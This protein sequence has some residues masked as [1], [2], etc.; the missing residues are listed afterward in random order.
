MATKHSARPRFAVER[1]SITVVIW[2]MAATYLAAH[3]PFLP[4]T[5]FDIDG[6]NFTL[7]LH[8]YDLAKHQPH[9]PGSPLFVGL[10]R[11][12]RTTLAWATDAPEQSVGARA[13]DA[14]A[15]AV[16]SAGFGALAAFGF[17][18]LYASLGQPPWQALLA[19]GLT[20]ASPLFWFSGVRPMSDV[21]GLALAALALGFLVPSLT[22]RRI[23]A[24]DAGLRSPVAVMLGCFFAG[25]APGM[26]I[27]TALLT[28]PTTLATIVI[29]LHRGDRRARGSIGA[30]LLGLVAWLLPLS[31]VAGGPSEYIRLVRLQ[32]AEDVAAGQM[33][34]LN[35]SLRNAVQ[36]LQDSLL[37]P[38]G[39]WWLAWLAITAAVIGAVHLL[40]REPRTAAIV[41]LVFGP[42]FALHLGFQDTAHLRYALP[43]V[44]VVALLATHGFSLVGRVGGAAATL[45]LAA[46]SLVVATSA[47][48]PQSRAPA[49]AYQALDEVRHRLS[50]MDG[51]PPVVAMHHSVSQALRGEQ[52]GARVLPS[53]L[54]YEWLELAK[55]WRNGGTSPVW[56]LASRRR[57]DLSLVDRVSRAVV[58]SYR[59]PPG[60]R[61]L[62]AGA[63]PRGVDWVE[64]QPPGWVALEGWSL[65][66]EIRGVTV[67]GY[68]RNQLPAARGF[69]RR[70]RDEA[71]MLLGGRNLG[72]PCATAATIGVRI[73]GREVHRFATRSGESF[74]E[75]WRLPSGSLDGDGPYAA[76][77]VVAEDRSGRGQL[78]DVA[79]EQFDVQSAGQAIAGLGHG[80]FEPEYE[81]REGLSYRW[82]S[83]RASIHVDAFGRDVILRLRGESPRSYFRQ[84][85]E[86][87]VRVSDTVVDSERLNS[88]FELE[89]TVPA[90]LLAESRGQIIL[91][92]SQAFVPDERSGNGDRRALALRI[93]TVDV[94]PRQVDRPITAGAGP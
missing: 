93:F 11:L 71:A 4:Q 58:E 75:I 40:I 59:I 41:A 66:P 67:H 8:E 10:G 56:F 92:A 90:R 13:L 88:D 45:G 16:W 85:T 61:L 64:I 6:V 91:E 1:P 36:A 25:L 73:D 38:W 12:A 19:T 18:R 37:A 76:L 33:L 81:T 70:R 24:D 43:L 80:W 62:L 26:R 35:P 77:E 31:L 42:Y 47:V 30:F 23:E 84:S 52:V 29:M 46:G 82:M 20:L 89:T 44:P 54:R 27:Q 65:S 49:P 48:V 32:A 63:R 2:L 51:E 22:R 9:P 87:V 34:A 74:T 79:F 21:P 7:A 53:P 3:V 5:P 78:V 68:S 69:V 14:G 55:Y 50:T 86:V 28:W 72:G 17:Y 39:T 15:L 57:T 83:D 94:R 60:A